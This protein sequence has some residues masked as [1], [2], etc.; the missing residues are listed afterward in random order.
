MSILE[1]PKGAERTALDFPLFGDDDDAEEMEAAVPPPKTPRWRSRPVL[2]VAAVVVVLALIVTPFAV[3]RGRKTPVTYA[4]ATA[5]QGTLAVTVTATGP[6]QSATYDVNFATSGTLAEIDVSV[7]QKVKAGQVLAKL[8]S[9]ALRQALTL[10]QAQAAQ[11]YDQEQNSIFSC[12]NQPNPPPNCVQAAEAQYTIALNQLHTA[13]QNLANA[14]LKAPHAGVIGAINGHIG[15]TPG[16]GGSSSSGGS[17]SSSSS[18]S[19]AF[20]EILDLSSLQVVADVNEADIGKLALGQTASFTVSA[21]GSRPFAGTVGTISPLGQATSNVVTYPVTINVDTNSLNG[22]SLLPAMTASVT[23]T[24]ARRQGVL[25]VPASAVTFARTELGNGAISRAQVVPALRQALQMLQQAQSSD[26]TASQ[27]NLS[28]SFVLERANN[29]WAVKPVVL[30]LTNG[31]VYEVL[32]GLTAG[33]TVITGQQGAT[34]TAGAGATGGGFG[35]GF[36][37]GRGGAGGGFGGFGGGR[38]G[39]NGGG[40]GSGGGGAGG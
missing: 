15:G 36:G 25:L 29:Q 31:S 12:N 4:S 40:G 37:G 39:G 13:Q 17:A 24:T 11:A 6:L 7:G 16:A 8:D 1:T 27:D 21:Y 2:I 33:D 18:S 3:L 22:A 23:I 38:G 28:A 19:G 26:P 9:T 30:G 5:R 10:A 20:I 34:T 32:A 35:G 14:T